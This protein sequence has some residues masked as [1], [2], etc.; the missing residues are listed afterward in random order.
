MVDT[1]KLTS[2][3]PLGYLLRLLQNDYLFNKWEVLPRTSILCLLSIV[4][5][6]TANTTL[7]IGTIVLLYFDIV[8]TTNEDLMI[9]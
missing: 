6:N 7:I 5:I 3:P 2:R 4:Y 9:R 1:N 8:R